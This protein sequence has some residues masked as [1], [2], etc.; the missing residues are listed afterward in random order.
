MKDS[1]SQS[2]TIDGLPNIMVVKETEDVVNSSKGK[3][4]YT[5][6]SKINFNS[7]KSACAI[8]LHMHQPLIPAGGSD[9][10]SAELISNLQHMME[11]Q[12]IGDNHNAPT[13]AW[14]YKRMGEFV[15]QLL[16]EGK[17]PRAMLEYSG[18]L[19][20]GLK[21]MGLHDVLDALRNVTV[22][23][24]MRHTIEWL[25]C[26]WG[27]A[28][29]PSTPVQDYKLHV[30]AWQQHFASIFGNEALSRV[31]GFSPSEMA[32]PNH[33]DIA[34]EFVKTLKD[35]GYSWVLVQEHTV[36]QEN[37]GHG[38][39]KKHL[40]HLLVC[41]N[42]EGKEISIV[43]LIK[44][45][46]SDTKLV[47]QMQPYYEATSLSRWELA[48]KQVPP[49]VTQIADGENGGVMMN[50]FPPKFQE[51]V[52]NAS[53]SE[54]PLMN[55]TE[56]LEHLFS[57]GITEHDLP[58]IQPLLQ[59]RIWDRVNPGDGP[60]KLNKSIEELK[61]EDGSFH[62]EGGSWTSDISWVKGY[63]DVLDPIDKLSAQFNQ[64]VLENGA[65][66]NDSKYLNA[67][68][69]LLVSQTSCY[70]YWGQGIWTDYAKEICRRGM[71]IVNA[72]FK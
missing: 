13:F 20:Y 59:K 63:Q 56:Y 4:V 23:P 46:G 29:A 43:A 24:E 72:N 7:I 61:K 26:P 10:S 11:N 45:Q 27:H 40:P 39:E 14:C 9:L 70:R 36:E 30:K 37:T 64:K 41:K 48:G 69:H 17:E 15:P 65:E 54:V 35:C 34:Y 47:A 16:S 32:L 19:F 50:E 62:V 1:H 5:P 53:G 55:G 71:E 57:I 22:N 18:T 28:V 60:E 21:K 51:V 25:G 52:R 6:N 49:L 67:L 8:A 38:L 3:A 33:P 42:S 66:R 44:T 12:G 2:D 31:R 58:R 68:Y